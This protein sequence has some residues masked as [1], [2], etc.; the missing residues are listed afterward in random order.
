ISTYHVPA[1]DE[2]FD[3]QFNGVPNKFVD[4]VKNPK[5]DMRLDLGENN[6]IY[7]WAKTDG[8]IWQVKDCVAD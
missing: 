5:A 3:L 6:T 2:E 7:I 4:L 1:E 8:K